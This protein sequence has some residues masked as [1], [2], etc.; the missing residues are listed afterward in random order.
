MVNGNNKSHRSPIHHNGQEDSTFAS[1]LLSPHS[2]IEN[3]PKLRLGGQRT[4]KR[5]NNLNF[6]LAR[7]K[8][9]QGGHQHNGLILKS[10]A[11][12]S[13]ADSNQNN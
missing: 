4:P 2:N 13:S 7:Q 10:N 5:L 9:K 11:N 3:H 12:S 8:A 6:E 1:N